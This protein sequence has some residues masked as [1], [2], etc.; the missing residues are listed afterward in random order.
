MGKERLISYGV[1][2]PAVVSLLLTAVLALWLGSACIRLPAVPEKGERLIAAG[3]LKGDMKTRSDVVNDLRI[4]KVATGKMIIIFSGYR[5][6]ERGGQSRYLV[7]ARAM[8]IGVMV[9]PAVD[10]ES[11]IAEGIVLKVTDPEGRMPLPLKYLVEYEFTVE[12]KEIVR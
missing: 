6:P 5:K 7:K 8:R 2:V 10:I 1:T 4:T 11:Y 9:V 12:V 3:T